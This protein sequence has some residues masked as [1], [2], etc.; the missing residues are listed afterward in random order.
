MVRSLFLLPFMSNPGYAITPLEALFFQT[1]LD[2]AGGDWSSLHFGYQNFL[3]GRPKPFPPS[4]ENL[5]EFDIYNNQPEHFARLTAYVKHQSINLVVIFDVQPVHPIF[6][7]LRRSGV[8]AI[9]AYIGAPI[10]SVMPAWKLGLKRLEIVLSRSKLDG[11]IFE[12]NAMADLAVFGRGVPRRM[13]SVVP[14]GV[15]TEI[16][17]PQPSDH[18]YKVLGFPRDRKIVIYSGHMERRKGVDI[19]IEAAIEILG[20]RKRTDVSFLICGNRNTDE[21][22]EYERMYTGLG[23]DCAIK[24][25]GYRSDMRQLFQ[26]CFCGVIPSSGWDSFTMTS[27]EMAASGLPVVASRLGGLPEAVADHKTGL[28]F[29]P[30]DY[31]QLADCLEKL[32]D[33]PDLAV[34][35]GKCGRKRCELEF[36]IGIQR[37]QFKKALLKYL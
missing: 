20:R 25:G 1:G 28:L 33:N 5:I 14:L 2:L 36:S 31:R 3:G 21:C 26:S 34:N 27:L 11:M 16:F 10:S 18:A 17:Q 19:L 6:S 4:F 8:T 35:Y 24:F 23:L 12:S 9:V 15:D 22:R 37:R 7:L 29:E 13:I 30:G 32:L